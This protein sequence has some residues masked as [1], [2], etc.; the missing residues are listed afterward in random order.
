MKLDKA[1]YCINCGEVFEGEPGT[2]ECPACCS[3]AT[4]FI[5]NWLGPEPVAPMIQDSGE[6]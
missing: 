5:E 6:M 1:K 2:L 4:V 3:Q